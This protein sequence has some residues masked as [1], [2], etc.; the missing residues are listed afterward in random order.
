MVHSTRFARY[1]LFRSNIN[2]VLRSQCS[3]SEDIF[4]LIAG[5][6]H[7]MPTS[8][9]IYVVTKQLRVGGQPNP[10]LFRPINSVRGGGILRFES[11]RT[12]TAMKLRQLNMTLLF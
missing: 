1:I 11:N 6:K 5:R 3:L 12:A 2:D 10:I 9:A 7:E 8:M 4:A